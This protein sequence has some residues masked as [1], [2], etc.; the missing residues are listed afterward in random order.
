MHSEGD[1]L[2]DRYR[3]L[4][5]HSEGGMS[6]LYKVNDQRLQKPWALKELK[7]D[8]PLGEN[9]V[10]FN[11][12]KAEARML[13]EL[14]HPAFPA[15]VDF[16]VEKGKAYL[17]E[18]WI[19][20]PTL[21]SAAREALPEEAIRVLSHQLLDALEH[22]HK[23]GIVYRDMKPQ[24]ILVTADTQVKLVDFGTARF[25]KA[26][27][28]KDTLLVGTP[29]YAPPE[30]YGQGQTDTR[31]DIYSLGATMYFM[32]TATHP[33][34]DRFDATIPEDAARKL[35]PSLKAI[36]EKSM[37]MEPGDRFQT[38]GEFRDA[39]QAKDRAPG[40]RRGKSWIPAAVAGFSLLVFLAA[41][42]RLPAFSMVFL[43]ILIYGFIWAVQEIRKG[44]R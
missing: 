6:Y 39:L 19:E 8:G 12:F 34:E 24:N 21:E 26:G 11:Q 22:L 10:E 4:K 42:V 27:K 32:A 2:H 33:P 36:M 20:G 44:S 28:K 18:E 40:L 14:S 37:R 31:T 13:A 30:Q 25:Y 7:A 43:G 1:L 15:V 3:V 38:T 29:G 5:L 35:S 23:K 41:E 9:S 17:V 16:F